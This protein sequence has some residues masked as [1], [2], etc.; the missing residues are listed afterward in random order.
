MLLFIIISSLNS[1][2]PTPRVHCVDAWIIHLCWRRF[3]PVL[4]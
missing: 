4:R 2:L 1:L 3:P